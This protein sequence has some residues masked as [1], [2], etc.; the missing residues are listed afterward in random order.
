MQD[1]QDLLTS[2]EAG[3]LQIDSTGDLSLATALQ[4]VQQDILWRL[5]TAHLD[6]EP[7]PYIGADLPRYKRYG[8]TRRTA[9]YMKAAILDALTKDG[10]FS[11]GMVAVDIVPVALS[12]VAVYVFVKDAVVGTEADLYS[13]SGVPVVSA[14]VDLDTGAITCPTGGTF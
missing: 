11:S 9:D 7:D 4:T 8:N 12:Q 2:G 14:T 10:R 13:R 3:D 6:Y 1:K 5:K